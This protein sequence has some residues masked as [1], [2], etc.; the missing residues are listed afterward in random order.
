MRTG[1][2]MN[3]TFVRRGV[4]ALAVATAVM[5]APAAAQDVE[6]G[7]M[8][9]LGCW[10]PMEAGDDALLCV[11]P[12]EGGVEMRT[13]VDGEVVTSDLISADGQQRDRQSEEC[14]GW[15]SAEFSANSRLMLASERSSASATCL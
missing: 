10:E 5:A 14:E 2:I 1:E 3:G 9:F 12:V 11:H 15:E 7:W 8:A 13:I 4:G 6:V